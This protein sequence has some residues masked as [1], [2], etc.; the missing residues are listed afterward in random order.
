MHV[1]L[2]IWGSG[3]TISALCDGY[4][5]ARGDSEQADFAHAVTTAVFWPLAMCCLVG[6]LVGVLRQSSTPTHG[7]RDGRHTHG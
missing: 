4:V 1:A 6:M 5:M 7:G 2:I 3:A